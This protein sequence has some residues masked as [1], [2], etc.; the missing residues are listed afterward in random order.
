MVELYTCKWSC[1][2]LQECP[3]GQFF[4]GDSNDDDENIN[5]E[6]EGEV[7]VPENVRNNANSSG[8]AINEIIAQMQSKG[9][10]VNDDNLPVPE[11]IFLM[12]LQSHLV[13]MKGVSTVMM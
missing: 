3:R 8:T 1:K 13:P 6:V 7:E 2:I 5:R 11:R 4:V 10:F 9:Y 12:Q